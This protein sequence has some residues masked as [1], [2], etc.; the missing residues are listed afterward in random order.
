MKNR[1]C[2]STENEKK[3]NGY[4]KLRNK[5]QQQIAGNHSQKIWLCIL[6][7]RK[8]YPPLVSGTRKHYLFRCLLLANL[9]FKRN[10]TTKF[11]WF[12]KQ[13]TSWSMQG[14]TLQNYTNF[15]NVRMGGFTI[16]SIL[17]RF[18]TYWFS[19]VSIIRK[20][21]KRKNI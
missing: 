5:C 15:L 10:I 8:K 4:K 2:I 1:S 12:F 20:L 14:S 17:P 21:L 7:I 18:S 9:L 11:S 3:N 13:R 19:F 16:F 6:G